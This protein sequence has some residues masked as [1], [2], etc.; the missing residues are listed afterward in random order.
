MNV[1]VIGGGG[2][3]HALAWKLAQSDK[4]HKVYL[5][6]GNGGTALDPDFIHINLSNPQELRA[7][8]ATE[9]IALTVVGPE[10]PLAA[11]VVDEFR[12]HG[13]KILSP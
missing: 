10:G 13:P 8:A 1:L 3:E 2:R 9:K 7:W 5:A 11:G 12:A 6:P 4:V